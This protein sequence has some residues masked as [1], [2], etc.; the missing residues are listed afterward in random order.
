M[1]TNQPPFTA[2]CALVRHSV[3]FLGQSSWAPSNACV[4][5]TEWIS[6]FR[7]TV[8][9]KR[10]HVWY[11]GGDGL[12]RFWTISARTT[13][14][15]VY[16]V[17][18]LDDSGPIKLPLPPARYTT[19]TGDVRGS[20]CLQVHVASAFLRG[21]QRNVGVNFK[22]WPSLVDF[23]AAA[24]AST[25]FRSCSG[26]RDLEFFSLGCLWCFP[27]FDWVW[28]GSYEKTK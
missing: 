2:E 13:E 11:K 9:S 16:L 20:W 28:G 25:C 23:Q 6:R 21:I 18:F 8:L 12:W 14:D 7:V 22:A 19:S 5:R 4:T 10:V 17:R 27:R 15:G 26:S 1:P 24:A 3:S